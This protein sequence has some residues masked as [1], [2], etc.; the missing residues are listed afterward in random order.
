MARCDDLGL[1]IAA[2]LNIYF[3]AQGEAEEKNVLALD[4]MSGGFNTIHPFQP[5]PQHR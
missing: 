4:S 3:S 2:H 5:L 1:F